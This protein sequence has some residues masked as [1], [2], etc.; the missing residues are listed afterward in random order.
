MTSDI[1]TLADLGWSAHF[2]Q[3][4][5]LE[6]FE[7]LIPARL[8][9]VQRST[10]TAMHPGGEAQ[11]LVPS[12]QST[13]DYAI[14]DWVV[15]N[16][17]L[18]RIERRLDRLSLLERRAAGTDVKTQLMAANVNTLFV[19]SSCN[20]D[21][22]PARLERYLALAAQSDIQ[23]VMVL[24]KADLVENPDTYADQA[25]ALSRDLPVLTV[26]ARSEAGVAKLFDWWPKQQTAILLGSSGVG[27]STLVNSLTGADQD[28]GGIREDDAK[29]RHT[30]TER[31]LH[32]SE[33]GGWLID[34]PGLR[35][36]RL[37][38]AA[39][40][41]DSVFAEVSELAATCRFSDCTHAG[42]PGCAVGAAIKSG[43]LDPERLDRWQKLRAEDDR[44]SETLEQSR[45][46]AK[47]FGKVVKEAMSERKRR[48]K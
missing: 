23:P 27:K 28:T 18:L 31:S 48:G 30:T 35:A 4:L 21:F 24:T 6:E 2:M 25:R 43:E 1:F 8:S 38:S 26:D 15:L 10:A 40:G 42:E 33:H 37:H 39:D 17:D 12:D 34:T 19:V 29:G 9:A 36:L 5:E 7:T 46:R 32:R 3:Q 14:G 11:V 47:R 44:N 13:G 22:N 16:P 41:I 45:K 20:D